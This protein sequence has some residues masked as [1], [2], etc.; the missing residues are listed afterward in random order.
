MKISFDPL[1]KTLIDKKLNKTEFASQVS[2]SKSTLAKLGKN[3]YVSLEVIERICDKLQI[4]I[5][6]VVEIKKS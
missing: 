6:D 5:Y 2:L 1:W 4:P 3:E